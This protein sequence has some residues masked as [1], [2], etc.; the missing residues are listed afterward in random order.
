MNYP[1]AEATLNWIGDRE[2]KISATELDR[3]LSQLRMAYPDAATNALQNLLDS[4][5]TDRLVSKIHNPDRPFD[6]GNREQDDDTYD[7]D[8]PPESA[9]AAARLA[10]LLQMTWLSPP[11]IYYGDEVGIWGS[12]DPNNRK[13]MLWDDLEPYED[14]EYRIMPDHLDFYRRAVALR[15]GS[16]AL[17]RGDVK[18][19]HLDDEQD[20][21][22][23]LRTIDGEEMLIVLNASAQEVIVDL[24]RVGAG[25]SRVFSQP[26]DTET[27]NPPRMTIPP[28]GGV[29]W[30]R[31]S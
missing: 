6:E 17:R 13:P 14:P 19:V 5:D 9:Y 4:H 26:P 12:D 21:F 30:R 18:T 11:M 7:G 1:F 2:N 23:F 3:R 20:T 22:A 27:G 15:K 28:L 29:V 24:P 10:V 8:K 16:A 25:W 31:T